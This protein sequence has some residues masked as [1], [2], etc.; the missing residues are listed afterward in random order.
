MMA[1][2]EYAR[3]RDGFARSGSR[4][5]RAGRRKW[6]IADFADFAGIIAK[7]LVNIE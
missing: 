3:D 6:R 2:L 7:K 1:L 5:D 4:K